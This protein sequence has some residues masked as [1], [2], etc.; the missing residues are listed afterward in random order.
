[1][2][3]I[4]LE[5]LTEAHETDAREEFASYLMPSPKVVE[6]V[7]REV[8]C[9]IAAALLTRTRFI[10][11]RRSRPLTKDPWTEVQ[12]VDQDHIDVVALNR[13]TWPRGSI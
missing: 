5:F 8:C 13:P 2:V 11:T 9:S 12:V 6:R 4:F 3:D 1:L 10:T 7:Q